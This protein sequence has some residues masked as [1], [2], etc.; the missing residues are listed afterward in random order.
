MQITLDVNQPLT[1][2][3]RAVLEVLLGKGAPAPTA[4][5]VEEPKA[6]EKAE[7]FTLE[8]IAAEA[9]KLM[10]SGDRDK[11]KKVL[12][13]MGVS[14]VRELAEDQLSDAMAKLRS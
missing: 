11:V 13:S 1:A 6:A 4:T 7:T 2:T 12:E 14:R 5:P 8:D 10:A 3:E 9:Q